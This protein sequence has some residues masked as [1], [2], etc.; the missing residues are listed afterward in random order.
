MGNS[1]DS[2]VLAL[3]MVAMQLPKRAPV[4]EPTICS[5]MPRSGNFLHVLISVVQSIGHLRVRQPL[6]DSISKVALS[7]LHSILQ[8]FLQSNLLVCKC[9]TRKRAIQPSNISRLDQDTNFALD[10]GMMKLVRAPTRLRG[11]G[12]LD[13]EVSSIDCNQASRSTGTK[14][15]ILPSKLCVAT[16]RHM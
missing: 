5:F 14:E 6:A 4:L 9:T 1:G 16:T 15:S 7:R 8:S 12:L 10:S 3:I 2:S 11:K 13:S